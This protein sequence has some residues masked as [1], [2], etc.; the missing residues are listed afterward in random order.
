MRDQLF[1]QS[2]VDVNE[3][4]E[5]K[6]EMANV[7][8]NKLNKMNSRGIVGNKLEYMDGMGVKL[9][10]SLLEQN[11]SDRFSLEFLDE[12]SPR[13]NKGFSDQLTISDEDMRIYKMELNSYIEQ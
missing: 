9:L 3:Y 13:F 8:H 1:S 7:M 5:H 12:T 10:L 6:H 2:T 11:V 4:R